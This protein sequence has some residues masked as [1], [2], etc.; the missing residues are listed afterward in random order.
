MEMKKQAGSPD[1]VGNIKDLID[2]DE[3]REDHEGYPW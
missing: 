1:T 3:E 2:R